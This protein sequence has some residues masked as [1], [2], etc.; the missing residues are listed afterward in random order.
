MRKNFSYFMMLVMAVVA[1]PM[2]TSCD[3]DD[4]YLADQLRD[5]DWQGYIGTYYSDRWGLSGK[6]FNTVMRFTSKE[7]WYTSGR[8][9]ELDYSTRS[10][11]DYAYCTFKWFIVDGEITLIYDDD[12]WQPIYIVDYS[13]NSSRFRGYIYDGSSRKIKF[14]LENDTY[15]DWDEYNRHTGGY[16]DFSNQ[17]YYNSRIAPVIADDDAP[18]VIDRTEE[19][20]QNSGDPNAASI[21]SGI[22]AEKFLSK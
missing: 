1:L 21:V 9:E 3:E 16:G 2:L 10:R 13:L 5:K 12:K 6:D 11:R 19:A 18:L 8:G 17:N 15:D 14:D 4:Q 20:R 22:F 7:S